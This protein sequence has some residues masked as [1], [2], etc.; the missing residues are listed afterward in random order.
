MFR[1]W[2]LGLGLSVGEAL[3]IDPETMWPNLFRP[4]VRACLLF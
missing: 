2:T 4:F 1:Y 3:F